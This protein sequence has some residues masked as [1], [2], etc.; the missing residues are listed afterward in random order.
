[1]STIR[2]EDCIFFKLISENQYFAEQKEMAD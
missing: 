2:R 1:M